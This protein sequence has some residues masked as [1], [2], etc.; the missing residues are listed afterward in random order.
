MD[1]TNPTDSIRIS[2]DALIAMIVLESEERELADLPSLEE[3][4]RRFVPSDSFKMRIKKIFQNEARAKQKVYTLR[5][6][7]KLFILCSAVISILFC[8]LLPACAV[9]QAV[10]QTIL[11]WR[12]KF[13]SI[14]FSSDEPARSEPL[15]VTIGY[16][17]DGFSPSE[18]IQQLSSSY[19]ANY[20]DTEDH[21]I[22]ILIRTV[23]KNYTMSLDNEYSTFYQFEFDGN[24]AIWAVMKDGRNVLLWQKD[25]LA[26]YVAGNID[27]SEIVNISKNIH[28]N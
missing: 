10:V 16:L 15:D 19:L 9:H 11:D 25:G 22:T 1:K 8:M 23:D 24:Q 5:Y 18:P 26:Y 21:W 28:C 6:L 4:N 17:P 7:K 14:T 12:D 13:V 2:P 3:L 20:T 27:L